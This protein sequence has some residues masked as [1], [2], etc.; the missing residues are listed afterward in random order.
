[1][2]ASDSGPWD[3]PSGVDKS[4]AVTESNTSG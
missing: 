3:P 2:L 1:M 4:P